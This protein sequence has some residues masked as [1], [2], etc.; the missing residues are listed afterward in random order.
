[1]RI[2]SRAS[3]KL[4]VGF[5]AVLEAAAA[6]LGFKSIRDLWIVKPRQT[7]S[8]AR[9]ISYRCGLAGAARASCASCCLIRFFSNRYSRKMKLSSSSLHRIATG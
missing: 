7:C 6:M 3:A 4:G 2:G 1:M 8:R 5:V 9:S